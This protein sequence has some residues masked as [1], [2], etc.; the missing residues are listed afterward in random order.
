[1]TKPANTSVK[2]T[3]AAQDERLVRSS[4]PDVRGDRGEHETSVRNDGLDGLSQAELDQLVASEFDQ[5]ALPNAPMI[6]GHHL[7]WL[8]TQSKYDTL[9]KRERLGYRPVRQSEVPGF[10]ASNGVDVASKDGNVTC[11]E[12]ILY[13]I[14]EDMYQAIMRHFHHKRPMD[15]EAGIVDSI[16]AREQQERDSAGKSL[17]RVEGEGL[18]EL[19]AGVNFARQISPTFS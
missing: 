16:K 9:Q 18:T 13:K 10:D 17:A 14:R 4:E 8:T 15:E 1:M 12:M 3:S 2:K 5:T 11:N 7:V 19:E 6:P